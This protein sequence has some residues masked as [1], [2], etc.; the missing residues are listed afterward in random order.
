VPHPEYLDMIDAQVEGELSDADRMRLE[1]HAAGCAECAAQ[2]A[3]ARQETALLRAALSS[4]TAPPDL[5]RRIM[6]RVSAQPAPAAHS[7]RRA[8]IAG[9]AG[10]MLT[11]ALLVMLSLGTQT[12]FALMLLLALAGAILW[13]GLKGLA[14]G[15]ILRLLPENIIVRGLAFGAGVWVITNALLAALGGFTANPDFAPT[16]IVAGSLIH[17]LIYGVLTSVLYAWLTGEPR[18]RTAR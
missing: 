1:T 7:L 18:W 8:M 16:F 5:I 10:N 15:S 2:W 12:S 3:A 6:H 9:I 4:P 11:A 14:F 13:G 17:H